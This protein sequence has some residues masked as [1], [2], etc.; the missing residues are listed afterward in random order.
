MTEFV[1]QDPLSKP[2]LG[3]VMVARQLTSIGAMTSNDLEPSRQ[4]LSLFPAGAS[5]GK[6]AT[7]EIGCAIGPSIHAEDV[8]KRFMQQREQELK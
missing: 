1:V 6:G 3:R 2:L 8:L 5:A 4:L 7:P